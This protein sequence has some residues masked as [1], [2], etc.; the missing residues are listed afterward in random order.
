MDPSKGHAADP[1]VDADD[2]VVPQAR[3]SKRQRLAAAGLGVALT[4]GLVAA[5]VAAQ[6]GSNGVSV[7]PAAGPP[8][9]LVDEARGLAMSLDDPSPTSARWVLSDA[10][11][12]APAVGLASG[13]PS[14]PRYLIV[15][16]GHFTADVSRPLGAPAPT[17]SFAAA[18]YDPATHQV[19]D[20]G[21]SNQD[22]GVPGLVPFSLR[23][24]AEGT[25]D[26]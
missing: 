10:N 11:T 19:T 5:L 17:G 24:T 7:T 18:A 6:L 4:L 26:G 20:W 14:A 22:V 13:D 3:G 1:E 21:V 25:D 12:V 23:S 9:W 15:L 2:E 16:G 8:S